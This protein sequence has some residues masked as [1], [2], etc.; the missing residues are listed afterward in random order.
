MTNDPATQIST[1]LDQ[2]WVE[3]AG[4]QLHV[5]AAGPADGPLVVLLHGFPEFWYGWRHQIPALADAGYRVLV[6]DQRG[7]NRSDAPSSI[8]AYDLAPLMADVRALIDAAGRKQAHVV[9][10]DWG[11]MVAWTLALTH[12]ERV[13]RS[14]SGAIRARGEAGRRGRTYCAVAGR[15][16]S[17][18]SAGRRAGAVR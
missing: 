8:A 12:P 13:R 15:D 11:A 10:H 18:A 6:P 3:G 9:G 16:R 17:G 2:H 4:V 1:P 7:Y 5:R 14:G